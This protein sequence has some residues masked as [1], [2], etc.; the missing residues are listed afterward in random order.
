MQTLF[1]G[2]RIPCSPFAPLPCANP[3]LHMYS[4]CLLRPAPHR[5]WLFA[6]VVLR[7]LPT[8]HDRTH[9]HTHT[10]THKRERER[11]RETPTLT[12]THTLSLS[13]THTHTHPPSTCACA[14]AAGSDETPGVAGLGILPG[15][16]TRFNVNATHSLSVPQIGW[17]GVNVRK[18]NKVL[19]PGHA[20]YYYFVHSFMIPL[21]EGPIPE[22]VHRKS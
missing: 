9:T 13:L 4:I 8:P 5:T 17:N 12:H 3:Y 16:V 15:H 22:Y 1:E 20:S 21:R 18:A 19:A 14:C 7:L 6:P 10:R 11:E 2:E